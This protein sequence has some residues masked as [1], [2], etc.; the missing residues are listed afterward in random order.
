MFKWGLVPS[1][2]KDKTI[3]YKMINARSETVFEKPSFKNAIVRQRCLVPMNGFF[4]WMKDGSKKIPF[5]IRRNDE[6]VLG[7]AGLFEVWKKETEPLY[8]FTI[9]TKDADVRLSKI[10]PRM[11]LFISPENYD[12]WLDPQYNVKSNI[13]KLLMADSSLELEPIPVSDQVNSPK[14]D[15]ESYIRPI[16]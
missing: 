15:S 6:Q 4:E 14:N 7:A 13:Q 5:Y 2:A 1:W 16:N 10:H 12:P 11:P 9:L 8:S 3:G